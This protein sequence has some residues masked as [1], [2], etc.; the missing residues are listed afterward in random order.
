MAARNY[1]GYIEGWQEGKK[2]LREQRSENAKAWQMFVDDATKNDTPLTAEALDSFRR[3]LT[4]G[5]PYF[6]S[7]LP[8]QEM[9]KTIAGKQNEQVASNILT[10]ATKDAESNHRREE[11]GMSYIGIDDS[12][13]Q[14]KTKI[15]KIFGDQAGSMWWEQFGSNFRTFQD[16]KANEA[17]STLMATSRFQTANAP[18]DVDILFPNESARVKSILR[19]SITDRNENES[20][21]QMAAVFTSIETLQDP[22]LAYMDE[23]QLIQR[24]TGLARANGIQDPNKDQIA[25]FLEAL[26]RRQNLS[27]QVATAQKIEKLNVLLNTPDGQLKGLLESY[28]GTETNPQMML[29][30]INN[31]AAQVGLPKFETIEKAREALGK[32]FEASFSRMR[33]RFDYQKVQA[34]GVAHAETV[35]AARVNQFGV[36][37]TAAYTDAKNKKTIVDGGSAFLALQA[38]RN[39][40]YVLADGTSV[41]EVVAYAGQI[42]NENPDAGE[43]TIRNL[44]MGRYQ[45]ATASALKASIAKQYADSHGA[46]IV[47]GESAIRHTGEGLSFIAKQIT[48]LEEEIRA[49]GATRGK[50]N[51]SSFGDAGYQAKVDR[52]KEVIRITVANFKHRL[53][54]NARAGFAEYNTTVTYQDENGQTKT[55]SFDA[56]IA[57]QIRRAEALLVSLDSRL[58]R[59]EPIPAPQSNMPLPTAEQQANATVDGFQAVPQNDPTKSRWSNQAREND[60]TWRA[61]MAMGNAMALL[62]NFYGIYDY[63]ARSEN[64]AQ[65]VGFGSIAELKAW[66]ES[67][68]G[69][70]GASGLFYRDDPITAWLVRHPDAAEHLNTLTVTARQSGDHKPVFD[71]IKK[72]QSAIPQ[73]GNAPGSQTGG[74]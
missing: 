50:W 48:D 17:A 61:N 12:E 71:F 1:S 63:Y 30:I 27:G 13:D 23:T 72:I 65:K 7:A 25:K 21:K 15:N 28:R 42:E 35:G 57:D 20:K 24:V 18:E 6:S 32:D 5:D 55:A 43:S 46:G 64:D 29:E 16:K 53:N 19:Q 8:S 14:A 49:N 45:W 70:G 31:A 9:M 69:F 68:G 2:F 10:R 52:A 66:A 44:L 36:D 56:Y 11:I 67:V 60:Q 37:L 40:G 54:S 74:G 4:G 39:S 34:E 38:I 26:K 58:S 33:A 59:V 22:E 51:G 41:S 3:S 47:P 62:D 73:G